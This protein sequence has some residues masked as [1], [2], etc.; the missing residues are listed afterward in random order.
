VSTVDPSI[1]RQVSPGAAAATPGDGRLRRVLL[2]GTSRGV[3]EGLTGARGLLLATLLGPEAFGAWAMFRLVMRY[4]PFAGLGIYGG[5]EREA[6]QDEFSGAAGAQQNPARTAVG[7]LLVIFLP[8][9]GL[10]VIASFLTPNPQLALGLRVTGAALVTEPLVLYSFLYLRARGSLRRFAALEVAQAV[11]HLSLAVVL[12]LRWGLAGAFAGFVGASIGS[13]AV[14]ARRVPARP[15][16]DTARLRRMLAIGFPLA[17]TLFTTTMLATADRLVVAA[18]GGTRLLGLYALAVSIAGIGG[19]MAWV[20]RTVIFPSVYRQ[21]ATEGA[22][23]AIRDHIRIT[24]L[25]F[26]RWFPP[27]LG[28]GALL[29]GPVI[30]VFLPAYAEAVGPARIFIFTGATTGLAGLG[31]LGVVA[32][33]L[34]RRL[35]LWALCALIVNLVLSNLALQSG[36]GLQ[37]VA[38]G[39]LAGQVVYGTAV[40]VLASAA[41]GMARP[42]LLILKALGP[43]FLCVIAVYTLGRVIPGTDLLS[44]AASVGLYF[45][46]LLPLA[47]FLLAD[48]RRL[49]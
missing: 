35:P 7:F 11:L 48:I 14:V 24:L 28:L 10:A 43:L 39:A 40:V 26:A 22:G 19:T 31:V 42:L 27:L 29:V 38:V 36:L 45:L 47:P 18:Y 34:Q 41:A 23:L 1:Q 9:A 30:M 6:V 44:V 20:V 4:A 17:L 25:P 5:L 37:G 13:L 3:T 16:L 21:A 46:V 49:R 33:D 8:L 15:A 12:A 32:A 2:Y